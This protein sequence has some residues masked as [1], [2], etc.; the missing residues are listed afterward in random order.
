M[1]KDQQLD[2]EATQALRDKIRSSRGE[3]PV[4]NF[5]RSIEELKETCKV[6]TGLE[7]PKQPV[8]N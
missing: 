5:G 4:F 1:N 7:P 6:E 3:L 8:F 2:A